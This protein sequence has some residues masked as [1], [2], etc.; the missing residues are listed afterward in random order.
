MPDDHLPR[1]LQLSSILDQLL[2]GADKIIE[3]PVYDNQL[4]G[5]GTP[6]NYC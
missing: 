2:A 6:R 1:L 5:R 4:N 3:G